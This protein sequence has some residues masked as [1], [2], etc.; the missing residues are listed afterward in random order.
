MNKQDLKPGALIY[1]TGIHLD[2]EGPG[3]ILGKESSTSGYNILFDGKVITFYAAC[4]L[5]RVVLS[6]RLNPILPTIH[7][8]FDTE[9][10][11]EVSND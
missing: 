10:I 6:A 7:Y 9:L 4:T 5:D 1:V 3:I 2:I 11:S 8:T